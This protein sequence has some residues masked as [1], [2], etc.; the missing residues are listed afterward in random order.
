MLHARAQDS[1]CVARKKL[2][3]VFAIQI[4][5]DGFNTLQSC[6]MAFNKSY[7]PGTLA[8]RFKA[9]NP[10]ARKE[11]HARAVVNV[12]A[13][14]VE[15]RLAGTAERGPQT[16]ICSKAELPSSPLTTDN[17]HNLGFTTGQA[18]PLVDN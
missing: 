13:Q 7:L 10:R 14:P 15:Q 17:A 8:Q 9:E 16:L 6:P 12:G 18:T 5:R 1:A 4:L 2:A 3:L 11:V